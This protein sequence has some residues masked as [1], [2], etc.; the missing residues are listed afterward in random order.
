MKIK[1]NTP[2]CVLKYRK[3]SA[4]E[5]YKIMLIHLIY[6]TKTTPTTDGDVSWRGFKRWGMVCVLSTYVSQVRGCSLSLRIE[7]LR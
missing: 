2:K 4:A 3:N 5:D 6:N 7:F 1:G